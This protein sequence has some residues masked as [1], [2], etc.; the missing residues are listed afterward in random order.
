[1]IDL[2]RPW[3]R[4][5]GLVLGL[6]FLSGCA[7]GGDSKPDGGSAPGL[8]MSLGQGTGTA[9]PG[10]PLA[11]PVQVA[12]TGGFSGPVTLTAL[13]LPSGVT[14]A[15][16][17]QTVQPPASATCT[18]TVG[19]GTP[20]GNH[21]VQIQGS[22]G[23][24]TASALF[25]LAITVPPPG[26]RLTLATPAG[27]L[28]AGGSLAAT[29]VRVEAQNGFSGTV[30]L[31]ASSLPPGVEASFDPVSLGLPGAAPARLTFTAAT[32]VS[33]VVAHP[34]TVS[35]SGNG[36]S[37][38][39]NF[40]LT[41]TN[42]DAP[43]FD[44]TLSKD[45]FT[46]LPGRGEELF[47]TLT[48]RNGF[49]G[50]V[51]LGTTALPAGVTASF[52]PS[53]ISLQ[54]APA[55]AVLRLAASASAPA[56]ASATAATVRALAGGIESGGG[57]G[58]R[59]AAATDPVAQILGAEAA[60]GARFRELKAQGLPRL[61][62]VQGVAAA[63][64]ALPEY[65]ASGVDPG[66]LC[67]WGRLKDGTLHVVAHNWD[68]AFPTPGMPV[69][70]PAGATLP[71]AAAADAGA[72]LPGTASA[73][74]LHSF[75]G[76]F[77]GQAPIQQMRGY[78]DSQGWGV[79]TAGAA[80]AGVEAL[81]SVA[82]NGFFYLNTH[83][84]RI[85]VTD[86]SIPDGKLYALQTST[87]VTE[88]GELAYAADKAGKLL[89]HFTANS[90]EKAVVNGATVDVDR[91]C[92]GITSFFVSRHMS[93]APGSVVWLNACFSGRSADF[94]NAF[95][96]KGATVVLGW[97][98]L[99]SFGTAFASVTHFVDRMV[100]ANLHA[101]V[102]SPFQRAFPYN[103]VLEDMKNRGLDQDTPTGGVL[104]A[105][106]KSGTANPPIFAPSIRYAEVDEGEGHL[107]LHGE[108]GTVPGKVTVD[109]TELALA[110]YWGADRL[111]CTLRPSGGGSSGD[112]VV[113]VNG[114]K[115]N[116]RQLTEW[117]LPLT[118][119]WVNVSNYLGWKVE[120][121]GRLRFRA[122]IGEYREKPGAAPV[123]KPRG[124]LATQDSRLELTASGTRTQGT[125]T[126]K[127]Q[128]ADTYTSTSA[129]AGGT[130]VVAAFKVD[131]R[132]RILDVGLMLGVTSGFNATVTCPGQG[133][134]TSPLNP[135]L[136]LMDGIYEFPW[137][138]SDDPRIGL[139]LPK[140]D[141]VL[142]AGYNMPGDSKSDT[143]IGGTLTVTLEAA[144]AKAP[145][146]NTKDS[147][148]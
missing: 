11:L 31:A 136:G 42:P 15:F 147:G 59:V 29:S 120:G 6:A 83:G 46:L 10:Q 18:F 82:G 77:G 52:T 23:G 122:D 47:V 56:G 92:Y 8:S 41:L 135:T 129:A 13:G 84:A 112:V 141:S 12:P 61:A 44:L 124:G 134:V 74:L 22:G 88:A 16:A 24:A 37:A 106:V 72:S 43:G 117:S 81:K 45:A 66:I 108:F 105:S 30:S 34:V 95:K 125:C 39:A 60:V 148:K 78:L 36:A 130:T 7:G 28:P 94:V 143:S 9:A 146:R 121:S 139:I 91:T 27:T 5:V 90:F 14:A 109:G 51:T 140:L 4:T 137:D 48:P 96:A 104:V 102:E 85:D 57:L 118:Y 65:L 32:G 132:S 89:V 131:G 87:P 19:A 54:G 127:L 26:I 2:R 142:D 49:A 17:P 80:G 69:Q 97:T 1:M 101:P 68:P 99:L 21:P 79:Q 62:V 55:S 86:P 58:I 53:S 73:R 38:T 63:M 133:T 50:S 138:Q 70:A 110:G 111:A 119:Q 93:F 75:G 71:P 3:N 123:A 145:P 144:A 67:A 35:A 103:L 25:T 114:V 40:L 33:P 64:A 116:A 100:G 76:G 98:E 126:Y 113:E 107:I 115:S 128:G 20:A